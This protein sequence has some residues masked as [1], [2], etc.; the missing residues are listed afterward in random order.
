MKRSYQILFLQ[1]T[2]I[3]I[4]SA[5]VRFKNKILFRKVLTIYVADLLSRDY[6]KDIVEEDSM[7]EVVHNIHAIINISQEKK[8]KFQNESQKDEVLK[9]VKNYCLNGYCLN[10]WPKNNSKDNKKLMA[11]KNIKNDF[12]VI[13]DI[14]I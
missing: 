6:S 10:G 8:I 1:G 14:I 3:K 2:T 12:T 13:E 7:L 11:Y 5:Q 4:K 9:K